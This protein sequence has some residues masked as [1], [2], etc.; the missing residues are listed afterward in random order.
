M[1]NLPVRCIRAEDVDG[2]AELLSLEDDALEDFSV[3]VY[4]Q[5][6]KV[7]RLIRLLLEELLERVAR[8]FA[9]RITVT[10]SVR[11]QIR[12]KTSKLTALFAAASLSLRYLS[13]A[14][15]MAP[16]R[17]RS[18]FFL[19]SEMSACPICCVFGAQLASAEGDRD[20]Y[21]GQK[22]TYH[23]VRLERCVL[24]GVT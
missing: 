12:V 2:L 4:V 23:R 20:A 17:S 21:A 16:R 9:G 8:L 15:R 11:R 6:G 5:Y 18:S 3:G 22:R 10:L 24:L 19:S 14:F 1:R 13:K 7:R